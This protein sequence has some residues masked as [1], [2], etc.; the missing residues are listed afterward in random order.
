MTGK[1]ERGAS[2]GATSV[3]SLSSGKAAVHRDIAGTTSGRACLRPAVSAA[4]PVS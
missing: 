4:K 1:K 3:T 2:G